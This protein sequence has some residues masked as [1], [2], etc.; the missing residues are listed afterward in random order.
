MDALGDETTSVGALA[1]VVAEDDDAAFDREVA[2]RRR[3]RVRPEPTAM[4]RSAGRRGAPSEVSDNGAPGVQADLTTRVVTGVGLVVLALICFKL[5]SAA[6]TFLATVVVGLAALELFSGLQR[7]GFR[8]ATIIAV[9]GAIAIVPAGSTESGA[10]TPRRLGTRYS[11]PV[12][13]RRW[14]SPR[15]AASR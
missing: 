5:G 13:I 9:L 15:A 2:A 12:A 6:T 10:T 14:N 7:R 1:E 8:P 11:R 4:G 3:I